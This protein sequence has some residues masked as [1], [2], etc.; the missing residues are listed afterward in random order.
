MITPLLNFISDKIYT[1]VGQYRLEVA[2]YLNEC[3][4]DRLS[5]LPFKSISI[6]Q[7]W[8]KLFE[9]AW[10]KASL[11][12][13]PRQLNPSLNYAILIDIGGEGLVYD[14]RGQCVM[15]ITNKLSSYGI[16]PDRPGKWVVPITLNQAKGFFIDASCNDLFGYV[17]DGGRIQEA[18]LA[19]INEDWRQL[20]YDVEVITDWA[21]GINDEGSHQ[22]EK[23]NQKGQNKNQVMVTLLTELERL[24][25][26]NKPSHLQEAKAKLRSFYAAQTK[27]DRLSIFATGH[28]HLDIAW[29]WSI[30]EGRR[31]ARRTFATALNLMERYPNY[32]FGASQYQLM[33]WIQQDEPTLF[34]R[35]QE[36]VQRGQFDLQGAFWVECDLNLPSLESIIRQ[37]YYGKQF[38]KNQFNRDVRFVWEP[39]VFGLTGALP[40]ILLKSGI[41]VVLSQKLAQNRI[42]P[43][44]YHSFL[45]KGID[46]ST[47]AVHHFPEETYDSR[48]RPASIIKLAQ[49]YKE[50]D[51]VPTALMVFGIGDGGGGPGEEHMERFQRISNLHPLPKINMGTVNQFIEHFLRY[52]DNLAT[53]Q[54]ELYFERHQGTYTTEVLNKIGNETM[55]RLL[56]DYEQLLAWLYW[57]QGESKNQNKLDETWKEVLLYQFHDILPGSSIVPVY[58]HTRKRYEEMIITITQSINQLKE[59]VFNHLTFHS[60]YAYNP[61]G[62]A[63]KEWIKN[64][65]LWCYSVIQPYS[66]Q[67]LEP[68]SFS[69]RTLRKR[70]LNN[71]IIELVIGEDGSIQSLKNLKTGYEYIH[72]T[73]MQ[74]MWTIYHE[75]AH[76]YPAWDYADNY[77]QGPKGYPEVTSILSAIDGP[78]QEIKISY[79]YKQ[80]NWSLILQL[81][82]KMHWIKCMCEMDWRETNTS[83]KWAIPITIQARYA[84]CHMQYGNIQRPTHNDD[85]YALAKDEIYAHQF[86]DISNSS[87]GIALMSPQK[88]G[89]RVKDQALE[90]SVLR[91]Q[92]KNGSELG[93]VTDENYP[94]QH[95]G[96]LV[97]HRFEF[98]IYPH[99][100]VD[101]IDIESTAQQLKHPLWIMKKNQRGNI[102]PTA[103]F[104]IQHQAVVIQSIKP[105]YDQK[106]IVLRITEISNQPQMFTID[107][108]LK[109]QSVWLCDLL[110]NP[111]KEIGLSNLNI[112][113]FEIL[114][115]KL[116][117]GESS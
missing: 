45:W 57:F 71:G 5:S 17:Q 21:Y 3:P 108:C 97:R 48:M 102:V 9:R 54:G 32:I 20:F 77:R 36:K 30:E 79:R 47:V 114:T 117:K 98:G 15:G 62:Y 76:E 75:L 86:I 74:P 104:S 11:N 46:G 107:T 6:G 14:E 58:H 4:F 111:I 80:S 93:L 72:S 56:L 31:K 88:Y 92:K 24:I 13:L 81:Y 40:Q 67:T 64:N 27:N 42:N 116:I 63:R 90:M 101:L 105:S 51:S 16:P 34:K 43:F 19:I 69:H 70:Q 8:G 33:E 103:F 55:E 37:I 49:Q 94:E 44:P 110:E 60:N 83:L 100:G 22:P 61:T 113:A 28:G 95:Y 115:I 91:S 89:F 29:L 84:T 59:L 68:V 1:R 41:D 52:K 106:G 73:N 82:E 50:K 65:N 23:S 38:L 66:F 2:K 78:M 112:K 26:A 99:E 35:I 109:I 96:D 18:S 12:A 85:S 39:D 53:V 7:S 87:R 10:F 25:I